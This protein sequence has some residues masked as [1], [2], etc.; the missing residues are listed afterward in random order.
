[1]RRKAKKERIL[2]EAVSGEKA[3]GVMRELAT[4]VVS[5]IEK[6]SFPKITMPSRTTDNIIFDEKTGRYKLGEK[7][8]TRSASNI[9]HLKPLSQMTWLLTVAADLIETQKTST[10]RDVFYMAEGAGDISFED[11]GESDKIITDLESVLAFAREDLNIYPEERSAI[12][13]DLDIEYTV[14]GYEGKKLNLT[15]HPDGVM[16]GPALATADFIQTSADKVI[17]IEKGAMFS[18][19]VEEKAWKRFHAVLIHTAGQ[20]PRSTRKLIRRLST[21]LRLP[22]YL[23]ADA[24]PWGLHICQVIMSGSA[25]AAHIADLVT[26]NAKWAGVYATDI[27]KYDLPSTKLNDMDIRRL[28][29]ISK[30]VRYQKGRWKKEIEHFF[31][32]KR[33]AEQEAFSKYG[34]SFIVDKYLKTR[35]D[36]LGA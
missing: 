8:V 2:T 4:D 15:I 11:Q 1:M 12:F 30:D 23:F 14:K 10:L 18:R 28:N 33:K 7:V 35:L 20:A 5:D 21:K 24:D 31:Q 34:L 36:E 29:E 3:L 9:R 17:A 19:F 6:E 32:T 22:V 25:N 16:I 26:P 13:G 27:S